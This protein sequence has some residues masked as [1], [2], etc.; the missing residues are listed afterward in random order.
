MKEYLSNR[1]IAD[2][3]VNI[4]DELPLWSAPFG[5][6]LLENINYRQDISALDIGFGSGFPLIELAMRLGKGSMVYGIDPCQKAVEKVNNKINFYGIKNI[7][8]IEG[9]AESIPLENQAIDLITSNNGINNVNDIGKTISECSRIIKKG[10]Q[11]VFTMNL[12]K[13]MFEFYDQFEEVLQEL[14]MENEIKLMHE[15]I[16]KKRPPLD[17]LTSLIQKHQFI[18]KDIEYDQF[19][20]NFR[21]G[22]A[23]LNHHQIRFGFMDSWIGLLPEGKVEQI[24]DMIEKRLNEQSKIFGGFKLSIPY[25]MVNAIKQ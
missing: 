25:V 13:T 6:K 14:N 7:K 16:A 9:I 8:I 17:L 22:T 12:E 18:I 15:H 4:E 11:F 3:S 5:I 24:F 21:N 20:Y 1:L 2:N 23:M 19:N 10:G